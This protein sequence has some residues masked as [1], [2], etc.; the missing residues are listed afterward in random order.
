VKVLHVI[1]QTGRGGAE[2]VVLALTADGLAHGDGVAVAAS[3]SVWA[4]RFAASGA[5]IHGVPL[6]RGGRGLPSRAAVAGLRQVLAAERPDLVHAHAVGVVLAT[7]AAL[8]TSGHRP[9]LLTTFHGVPP[10][11]YRMAA[12]AMRLAAPTVIACSQAIGD[13]LVAQG[14]PARRLDVIPNG[15]RLEPAG[16]ERVAAIRERYGLG[17]PLVAGIGRLEPQK[18]WHVLIEAAREIDPAADV[19]VA[20][21]GPLDCAHAAESAAAGG[22]VRFIGPVDDV[23]ALVEAAD[24]IVSTST[25][26][27]LPLTL[28]EALSLGAA[29]VV[30]NVDGVRNVIAEDTALTVP[31]GDAT[32]VAAAVN[33]VLGDPDLAGRLSAR[34]R[35]TAQDW[36]PELMLER[37]RARYERTVAARERTRSSHR[38]AGARSS[39]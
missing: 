16:A 7:R 8:L 22:R 38:R 23:A 37:Y 9:P 1:T 34:A 6:D 27:G 20:G 30:T 36:S 21:H 19:V 13:R 31:V 35:E 15:A 4:S 32:A 25:W 39:K 2:R 29:M 12:R 14:Y 17:R 3:P 26:E 28:L 5:E 24:C 11:Q 18:A 10:E 33:R